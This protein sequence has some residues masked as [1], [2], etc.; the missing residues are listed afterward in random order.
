MTTDYPRL[1]VELSIEVDR[2]LVEAERA[3]AL[4]SDPDLL[5]FYGRPWEW[6]PETSL[7]DVFDA[8]SAGV[9]LRSEVV[10]VS[11]APAPY[12]PPRVSWWRRL[13]AKIGVTS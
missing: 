1:R 5:N 4:E 11:D 3:L 7:L 12:E 13:L 9:I 2:D 10:R 8:H 6:G